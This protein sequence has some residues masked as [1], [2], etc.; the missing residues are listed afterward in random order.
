MPRTRMTSC[1]SPGGEATQSC[2]V[3][4]VMRRIP[5]TPV[6]TEGRLTDEER[7]EYE[8]YVKASKFIATLQAK[9]R[10]LLAHA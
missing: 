8:G 10:K 4:Q 2:V 6:A 1:A 5:S 9:A 3:G 7:A